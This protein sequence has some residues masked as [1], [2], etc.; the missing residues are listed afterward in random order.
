MTAGVVD[1]LEIVEIGHHHREMGVR[2]SVVGQADGDRF[3][4]GPSV[5]QAG[6]RILLGRCTYVAMAC[7][8]P[9]MMSGTEMVGHQISQNAAAAVARSAFAANRS[10]AIVEAAATTTPLSTNKRGL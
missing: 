1:A 6:Q 4:E 10:T 9:Q 8:M 3:G 2:G 7:V 5:R